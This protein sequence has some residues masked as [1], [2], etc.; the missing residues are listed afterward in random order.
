MFDEAKKR[1]EYI[2]MIEVVPKKERKTKVWNIYNNNSLVVI[3]QVKWY[4]YW[5]QYC[6]FPYEGSLFS[7][8]CLSDIINFIG[9]QKK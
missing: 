8:G 4:N 9:E 6:F 3:G 5:R 7:V 1:Y 2:T